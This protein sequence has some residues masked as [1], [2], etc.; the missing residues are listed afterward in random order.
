LAIDT[1]LAIV[2]GVRRPSAGPQVLADMAYGRR[3]SKIPELIHALGSRFTEHHAVQLCQLLDHID[4]LEDAI[5]TLDRR[6]V[7]LT[8]YLAE[9][10]E[11]LQTIAGIGLRTAET[12]IA[13]TRATF[14]ASR[15]RRTW[16]PRPGCARVTTSPAASTARAAPPPNASRPPIP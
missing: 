2:A 7:E 11:R 14:R 10:I 4:R 13:E 9:V 16:R 8:T 6:I 12:V 15:P 3:R 1:Q 5:S